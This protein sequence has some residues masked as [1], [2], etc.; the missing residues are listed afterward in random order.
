MTKVVLNNIKK[1]ENRIEELELLLAG[2]ENEMVLP[3]NATNV[4]KLTEIS[5]KQAEANEELEQLYGLWEELS[6]E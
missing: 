4:A 2:L 1:T 6:E 3:E 5:K